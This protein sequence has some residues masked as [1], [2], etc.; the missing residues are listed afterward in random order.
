MSHTPGPWHRSAY[1]GGWDCVRDS[2]GQI[3]AKLGLNS[4]ENA[5]VL[6]AAPEML[7]AL[8]A[9]QRRIS[10]GAPLPADD[11]SHGFLMEVINKAEGEC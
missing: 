9:I 3:I 8:K 1:D 4:P 11:V 2:E 10:T 5:D 7:E 6:A